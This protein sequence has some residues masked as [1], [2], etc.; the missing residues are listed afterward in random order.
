MRCESVQ[1]L[2][3]SRAR[4]A[5][6][7]TPC[8]LG[9]GALFRAAG[10]NDSAATTAA[11][12]FI[13]RDG[14]FALPITAERL[15]GTMVIGVVAPTGDLRR[16]STAL[17]FLEERARNLSR[18]VILLAGGEIGTFTLHQCIVAPQRN[19]YDQPRGIQTWKR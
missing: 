13:E 8:N 16:S 18:G 6:D 10:D 12:T 15:T 19:R 9:D 14:R 11:L 3:R 4:V 7:Q 5:N 2:A 17:T 1:L